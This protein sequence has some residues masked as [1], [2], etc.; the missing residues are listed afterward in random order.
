LARAGIC[1]VSG[2]AYGVDA[3]AHRGALDAKGR[4]IAV[5]GSGIDDASIYPRSNFRLAKEL[6]AEGGLIIS[7]NPPGTHPQNWDFPKRNRIIAALSR[8]IIVVE[9]PIKSGAL[10]TAKYAL[11]L[12][13]EVFVVPSDAL[14]VSAMGSNGLMTAGATPLLNPNELIN[15]IFPALNQSQQKEL[16]SL[17]AQNTFEAK[18]IRV[19]M[20]GNKHVDDI[21]TATKLPTADIQ[22]ALTALELR[23]VVASLGGMRYTLL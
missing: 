18:I 12:G 14:R 5:V 9:A 8:A 22:A 4:T 20:E 23:S 15:T 2:L 10:I 19:L 11:E 13:R 6:L 16:P 7:E 1:I 21:V 17:K 3:A